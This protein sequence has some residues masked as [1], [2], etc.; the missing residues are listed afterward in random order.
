MKKISKILVSIV[1]FIFFFLALGDIVEGS[2]ESLIDEFFVLGLSI[3]W[4]VYLIK[5]FK[6]PKFL[7][8]FLLFILSTVLHNV[9]SYLLKTEE[10]VFFILSLIFLLV[11]IALLFIFIFSL[12]KGNF[13]KKK[14][15]VD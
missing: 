3:I 11:S 14:N 10:P 2:G 6:P 8:A 13:F 1:V 5:P 7:I 12:I 15:K 4:F 9:I